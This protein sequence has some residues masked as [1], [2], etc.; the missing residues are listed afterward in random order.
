MLT[1][2]TIP[3]LHVKSLGLELK[4]TPAPI[5][6]VIMN[7]LYYVHSDLWAFG[8]CDKNRRVKPQFA[9]YEPELLKTDLADDRHGTDP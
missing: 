5:S 9:A 6:F 7:I 4:W 1:L 2:G 8:V 3:A